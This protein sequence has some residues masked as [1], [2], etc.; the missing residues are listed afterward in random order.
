MTTRK[1]RQQ[2]KRQQDKRHDK[3]RRQAPKRKNV[4]QLKAGKKMRMEIGVEQYFDVLCKQFHWD[5]MDRHYG[6]PTEEWT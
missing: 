4:A 5:R 1:Q 2:V 3:H 6:Q